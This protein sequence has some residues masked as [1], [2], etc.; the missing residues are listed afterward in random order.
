MIYEY[1]LAK[2]RVASLVL[3][4]AEREQVRRATHQK[5]ARRQFRQSIAYGLGGGLAPSELAAE[6][7][8]LLRAKQAV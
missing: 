4:T 2:E 3:L 8:A 7:R 1:T 6:L 5:R